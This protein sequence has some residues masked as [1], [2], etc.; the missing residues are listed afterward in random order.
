MKKL[1]LVILLS[2]SFC[3]SAHSNK[4]DEI[5]SLKDEISALRAKL[6][7]I[8]AIVFQMN[9][10]R[11]DIILNT[12]KK[13]SKYMK[14]FSKIKWPLKPDFKNDKNR[15]AWLNFCE[16]RIALDFQQIKQW[17]SDK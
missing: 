8:T 17:K 9:S 6:E 3:S 11:L 14:K 5:S 1:F 7:C 2:T 10:K 12:E 13:K 4:K 15:K 16:K